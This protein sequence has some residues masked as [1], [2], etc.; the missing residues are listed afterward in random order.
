MI[1]PWRK[2]FFGFFR[3]QDKK[4]TALTVTWCLILLISLKVVSTD[5]YRLV[6]NGI[7][8]KSQKEGTLWRKMKNLTVCENY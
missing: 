8:L 4:E 2:R 3:G 1:Y 7:D 5:V 6:L